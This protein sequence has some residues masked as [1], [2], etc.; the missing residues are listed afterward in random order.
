M[1][2]PPNQ[3]KPRTCGNNGGVARS[4]GKPCRKWPL[5]GRKNCSRHGGR[6]A[7]GTASGTFRH[8]RRSE[9]LPQGILSKYVDALR[10]PELLGLREEVALVDAFIADACGKLSHHEE[11]GLWAMLKK[12]FRQL[13][14]S[15]GDGEEI[16]RRSGA[17][18]AIIDSGFDELRAFESI[19]RHIDRRQ[20]L[21]ES[22]RKRMLEMQQMVSIEQINVFMALLTS[23]LHE[24]I[25]DRKVRQ[26]I[27]QDLA[28]SGAQIG[29]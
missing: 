23:I 1:K 2:E 9:H 20:R 27:S 10:D 15:R 7:F 4:T 18:G 14:E 13:E 11:P 22:E 29:L 24:R 16:L 25:T 3:D 12:E 26:L 19:G 6:T 17:I 21:V 5:K 8:G 28:A